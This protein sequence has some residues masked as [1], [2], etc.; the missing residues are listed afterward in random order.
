VTQIAL[1]VALL[2]GAS[3]LLRSF[4]RLRAIDLGYQPDRLLT[5]GL[6]MPDQRF[7]GQDRQRIAFLARVV[8]RVSALP[9]VE[10]ASSVMGLP[11]GSVAPQSAF[12]FDDRPMPQF[13]E[14][15]MA[16]YAQISANY[17]QT[18]RT[19]LVRGR[20]FDQRDVVDAP[21]VAIVNEAFVRAFLNGEEPLG[22]RLRVM[23][24]HRER[25]TE[26]VGVV[27]DM[28]QGDLTEPPKPQMF[29]PATQ[30]CWADAQIVL[31]TRG[32]PA[33]LKES[34]RRAVS[35]IDAAQ[36]LFPI[37]A[38][39][40][41]LD[42]ALAQRRLQMTL[43]A[44]FAG[45]ALLLA[46][47]GI[48]GVMAYSVTQRR[49]EIGVR[50]TLGAQPRQALALILRYGMWL[51][52][53]GVLIGVAVAWALTR[54][55]GSLLFEISPTDPVSFVLI[56]LLLLIVALLAC[57]LPARRASKVNPIVALRCE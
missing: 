35:E 28:R 52:T 22:K 51:A 24:S 11:M 20:A 32:E 29:F 19:P 14:M 17:F 48:Y 57:W 4:A 53:Q 26:I 3:L 12:Y 54:W 41:L 25:P 33:A 40:E 49:R 50:L 13:S 34:L 55:M 38:F 5:A 42:N 37:C 6:A 9:G 36:T 27:R 10:S 8:E 18:M 39:D 30:R 56:P 31:R 44:A 2:I 43:L 45:L 15:P 16:Q 1:A 23:D 7:P 47:V 21:F 46:A